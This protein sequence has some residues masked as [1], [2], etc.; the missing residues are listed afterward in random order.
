MHGDGAKQGRRRPGPQVKY[1]IRAGEK[2]KESGRDESLLGD[3]K[4]HVIFMPSAE[5]FH[6]LLELSPTP[7]PLLPPTP[8]FYYMGHPH[9]VSTSTHVMSPVLEA[10]PTFPHPHTT[11]FSFVRAI[12]LTPKPAPTESPSAPVDPHA[13]I[14][15]LHTPR[16]CFRFVT[17]ATSRS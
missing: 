7:T 13:F 16:I 5:M 12:L 2:V 15:S 14:Q 3:V 9:A 8:A 6:T 17:Y 11:A 4:I 10:A 1:L